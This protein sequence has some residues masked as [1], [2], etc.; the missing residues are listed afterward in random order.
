MKFDAVEKT[1]ELLRTN[2]EYAPTFASIIPRATR[3]VA[4]AT[5]CTARPNS[6]E[7]EQTLMQ[8]EVDC[9]DS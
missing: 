3:A 1:V 2:T 7:G 6:W 8:V 5:G 9:P 4:I